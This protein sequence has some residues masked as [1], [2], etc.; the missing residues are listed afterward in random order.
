MF[1]N[2]SP[3][4]YCA[5]HREYHINTPAQAV[6]LAD[7]AVRGEIRILGAQSAIE[8][9]RGAG[10]GVYQIYQRVQSCVSLQRVREH[11]ELIDR[12]YHD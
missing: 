3:R 8:L 1:T 10:L 12:H 2:A 11:C 4:I 7:R 5:V 6:E 9:Y